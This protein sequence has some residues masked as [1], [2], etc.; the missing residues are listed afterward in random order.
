MVVGNL[1][2]ST[3][4]AEQRIQLFRELLQSR[5]IFLIVQGV[6]SICHQ[7]VSEFEYELAFGHISISSSLCSHTVEGLGFDSINVS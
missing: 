1:F 3:L 5:V 7:Y 2:F 4:E 6:V